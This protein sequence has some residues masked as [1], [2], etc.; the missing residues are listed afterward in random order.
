M[1][2]SNLENYEFIGLFQIEVDSKNFQ[3]SGKIIYTSGSGIEVSFLYSKGDLFFYTKLEGKDFEN[4]RGTLMSI[5]E[6]NIEHVCLK[7]L[8]Y[9]SSPQVTGGS[10]SFL[11]KYEYI[12]FADSL[13]IFDSKI[14]KIRFGLSEVDKF[15]DRTPHEASVSKEIYNENFDNKT[16]NISWG[17]RY[18]FSK[19]SSHLYSFDNEKNTY[20]SENA[21]K[22]D[23]NFKEFLINNNIDKFDFKSIKN[24]IKPIID[25][26]FNNDEKN[27]DD[28]LKIMFDA[29]RLFEITINQ[30]II[31]DS[32]TFTTNNQRQEWRDN[33]EKALFD[34]NGSEKI[35]K[36]PNGG[37]AILYE[38]KL[39]NITDIKGNPC[40]YDIRVLYGFT[41]KQKIN[42]KIYY[43]LKI[44]D[45]LHLIV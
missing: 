28:S 29:L 35:A 6:R 3:L 37:D 18:T 27:S 19:F 9:F 7:N 22:I 8:L 38:K 39:V 41:R 21:D 4:I 30:S 5:P 2:L 10:I 15:F 24:D 44:L 26:A 45:N 12:L 36:T 25:L 32:I 1:N 43:F 23:N 17:F 16:I 13:E 20:Y 11:C 34:I 33:E 14:N 42:K 31:P 40:Y